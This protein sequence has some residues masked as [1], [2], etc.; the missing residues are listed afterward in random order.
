VKRIPF[1]RIFAAAVI[2]SAASVAVA[3]DDE[4][5]LGNTVPYSGPASFYGSIGRSTSAYFE[6]LNDRA[7]INGRKDRVISLDDGLQP[8]K[9]VEQTRRLVEQDE[10]HAM[11]NQVGT[12][13]A[14][15]VRKYL[16]AKKVPQIF[17][18]S[19]S[20]NFQDPK[21]FPYSTSGL[22]NYQFEAQVYGKQIVAANP[23]AKIGVLYQNDDFGKDYVAGLKAGAGKA[24]VAEFSYESSDPTVSSQV[25]SLKNAGV[26][27]VLLA[28][29]SK[30][31]SQALRTMVEMG[32]KPQVYISHVSAQIHPT[33]SIVGLDKLVG[34]RTALV[35][36]DPTDPTWADDPDMKSYMEWMAKYR[37]G[38][39]PKVSSN[40][41]VMAFCAAIAHVLEKAGDDLSRENILKQL[42]QLKDFKAP[43]LLPGV[44]MTISPDNYNPFRKVQLMQFDGTR[45][46]PD[47]EPVGL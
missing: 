18:L 35:N 16:N 26:D 2:A 28:A 34:L 46:V 13:T 37:P 45:W 8:P 9:T 43:M 14:S 10:V 40:A 27:T 47:G 25:I 5:R 36:K 30:Q 21:N 38:E 44:T 11:V 29:Y 4:I 24:V 42:T 1:A 6:M 22:M 3:A 39:D 17:V 19:G 32:W 20:Q 41:A 7:G 23:D 15:A 33:L 12:A 31:V